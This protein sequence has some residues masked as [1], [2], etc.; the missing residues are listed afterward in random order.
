MNQYRI[1]LDDERDPEAVIGPVW[2]HTS[3]PDCLICRTAFDAKR[4]VL[5]AQGKLRHVYFDHDLGDGLETGMD[6]AKWLVEKDMDANGEFLP[7]EFT[8]SVH[9]Q[10]PAGR[11]NIKSLM[12]SYLAAKNTP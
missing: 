8:F 10:N 6:F 11:D 1:F 12:T 9:S 2:N 5:E 3:L 7:S 4:V